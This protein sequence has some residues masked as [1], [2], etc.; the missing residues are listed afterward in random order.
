MK[1]SEQ[2]QYLYLT[3]L[4]D[5]KIADSI[6]AYLRRLQAIE[7]A[8][9]MP[10]RPGVCIFP[11]SN[12][13]YWTGERIQIL[14][15]HIDALRTQFSELLVKSKEDARDAE[16]YRWLRTHYIPSGRDQYKLQWYLP[17][18]TSLDDNGLDETIDS[19]LAAK[20]GKV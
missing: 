5:R 12:A 8:A 9:G 20:E 14:L 19:V 15:D 4:L 16:R 1:L 17:R 6:L 10:G 11:A 18:W 2:I 7:E 13:D 3:V